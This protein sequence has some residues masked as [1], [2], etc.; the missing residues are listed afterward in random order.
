MSDKNQDLKWLDTATQLMDNRFR[1]PGTDIRFGFDS[2][3]G[4]IPGLGDIA[5]LGVSG[6]LVSV[7]VRK[8]ASGMV[9]VKMMGNTLVD[10]II[11][12]IPILGDIFDLKFKA[13]RRN[14]AL[15]R[16]H[17]EEGEHEGSAWPVVI[18][19]MILVFG[20]IFAV[21]WLVWWG[22]AQIWSLLF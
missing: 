17:Y 19:I 5:T 1:I 14:L 10:T 7:M 11:G 3:L 13:N 12:S 20:F 15:L 21:A 18:V 9:V 16:E 2:L 22:L 8:G 4:L 6:I